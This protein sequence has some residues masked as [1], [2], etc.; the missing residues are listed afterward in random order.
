[1]AQATI[2]PFRKLIRKL[3]DVVSIHAAEELDDDKLSIL[4]LE[5]II[6]AVK[7]RSASATLEPAK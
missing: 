4:D 7:S 6:L 5:N 1:M 2:S 3:N